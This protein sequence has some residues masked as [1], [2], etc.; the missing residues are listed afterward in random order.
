MN[1]DELQRFHAGDP[2]L[3]RALVQELSPRLLALTGAYCED[4]DQAED[5]LQA[6]WVRAYQRRRSYSGAG[7]VTAWLATICR[8]VC[9]DQLRRRGPHSAG[10]GS[11]G[12]ESALARASA[13]EPSPALAT[14]RK[15]MADAVRRAVLSLPTRQRDT[16]ILR[17]LEGRS[18]RDTARVLGCAEGTVKAALHHALRKLEPL[19]QE[20]KP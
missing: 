7:S 17:M 11:A 6:A 14:E 1:A 19:L 8:N 13:T 3:F 10:V 5:L 12:S 15:R 16:V 9:L 18:V 4:A 2:A 20:W